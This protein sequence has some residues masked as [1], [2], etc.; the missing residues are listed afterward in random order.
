MTQKTSDLRGVNYQKQSQ[1]T[2]WE[3]VTGTHIIQKAN[4]TKI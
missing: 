1:K 2:N 3:N 4:F